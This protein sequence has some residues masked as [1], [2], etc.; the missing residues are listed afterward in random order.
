MKITISGASGFIGRRLLKTLAAAGHSLHVLSRHSGMNMPAGVKVFPWNPAQSEPPAESIRDADAVVHLAGEPVAQ[1]WNAA[2]K[3]KVRE[4]RVTGTENLVSA[5]AKLERKPSVLVCSSAIGYYGSRGDELL[6][7]TSAAGN[8]YLAEVC[9]SWETA[10]Q[11]AAPLGMRVVSVRTGH[12]LDPRGGL[13]KRILTPFKLG[14]GGKLGSGQQWM[15]WIHLDDMANLLQFAMEKPV[16]GPMNA[17][18]P[19]PVTNAEFTRA[20]ASQLHRPAIFPVPRFA[21]NLMFGEMAD[22][23][24]GSQ[25]VLPKTAE[26]A[27]F[28]FR[29]P[30][31]ALALENLFGGG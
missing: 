3:A 24:M 16:S 17:V 18:S 23:I 22:V 13:L 27:G 10:A 11:K 9:K 7:E 1:R 19:D 2:V 31:L 5:L 28:R 6:T 8:D 26:S 30:E 4:S 12:V 21:L 15:S 14:V 29:F 20:L 25:R